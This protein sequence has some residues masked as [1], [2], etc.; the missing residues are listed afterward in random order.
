MQ[1]TLENVKQISCAHCG[2]VSR[3]NCHD[4]LYGNDLST[5]DKKTIRGRRLW[6]SNR[7][8]RGGC[9]QTMALLFV[10]VLPRHSFTAPMLDKLLRFI[11]EGISVQAAWEKGGFQLQLQSVYHLLQRF[12]DRIGPLRSALLNFCTPP[13]SQHEDPLLQT[14]E[15]MHCAFPAENNVVECFQYTIQTPIM[16]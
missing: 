13:E 9:G 12:R 5:V 11:C 1:Q 4:T 6:C 10:W 15:H 16:G 7:D 14:L 2:R 8:K 3:L